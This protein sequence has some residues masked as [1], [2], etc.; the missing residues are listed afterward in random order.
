[1]L[2]KHFES[3]DGAWLVRACRS[4]FYVST[5]CTA[6]IRVFLD[7]Q[8]VGGFT[9]SAYYLH[10][11]RP[12]VS[13]RL[14]AYISAAATGRISLKFDIGEFHEKSVEKIIFLNWTKL[15]YINTWVRFIVTVDIKS[16]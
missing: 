2:L 8:H 10:H 14:Y 3:D 12:S 4:K 7:V 5:G 1:M 13:V 9:K 15:S 11:V 6:G 16:P